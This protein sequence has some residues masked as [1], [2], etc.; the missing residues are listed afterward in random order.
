MS[1]GKLRAVLIGPPGAGKGTQAAKI[2]EKFCLCHL[3][4]GDMLRAAV[5]AGTPMGKAAKEV[6]DAGKLV[7]DEIV[8][9]L[10][11]DNINTPAC[12]KGFLLDGFPRT[13]TQAQKL[14]QLLKQ[15][16]A[17]LDVA[18]EFA[19]D[20]DLLVRRIEGRLLHKPSGRTYH[21]EF[22]PPKKPMTDDVTGEPLIRRSDDNA[23]AL[24]NRLKS[25]HTQTTPLIDYYRQQGIHR[26]VHAACPVNVVWGAIEKIFNS[27]QKS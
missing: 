17:K 20:D 25:Y 6:M 10:I 7:S 21:T 13:V 15:D 14:D 8:V 9:G 3:A 19:I 12:A 4:T 22:K 2:K 18:L 16:S 26:A 1:D 24:K 5:A 11:K 27:C 23:E